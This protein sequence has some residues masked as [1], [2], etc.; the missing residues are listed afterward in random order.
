MIIKKTQFNFK[1]YIYS[2]ETGI[3]LMNMK[4]TFNSSYLFSKH[5]FFCIANLLNCIIFN[6]VLQELLKKVS[7]FV[8]NVYYDMLLSEFV[9]GFFSGFNLST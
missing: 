4:L 8:G 2:I 3:A 5:I 1:K 7:A 9:L 6:C